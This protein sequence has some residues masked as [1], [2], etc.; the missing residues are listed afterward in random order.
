MQVI[1]NFGYGGAEVMCANLAIELKKMGHDVLVVSLYS[2]KTYIVDEMI[3]NGIR[4]VSLG[5][6]GG[7]DLTIHNKELQ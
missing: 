4:F 5:K 2:L 3:G 7:I 6:K 1:P